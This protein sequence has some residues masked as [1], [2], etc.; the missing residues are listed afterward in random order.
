VEVGR[1]EADASRKMN[2]QSGLVLG[3]I[4]EVLT[5]DERKRAALQIVKGRENVLKVRRIT[6]TK[7]I[8][9]LWE[10]KAR[11]KKTQ[12]GLGIVKVGEEGNS[13]GGTCQNRSLADNFVKFGRVL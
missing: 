6:C 12:L 1:P 11:A 4:G 8:G 2:G 3:M 5:K 10:G 7:A 9:E 13:W